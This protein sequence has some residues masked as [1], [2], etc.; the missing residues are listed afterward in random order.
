MNKSWV[1]RKVVALVVFVL[2]A[3]TAASLAPSTRANAANDG[4]YP[5]AD[6]P[7]EHPPYAVT[8]LCHNYDWG[9]VR[10]GSEASTLSPEYH[11]GYRNCT[12]YVAW[13]LHVVEGVPT[14]VVTGLGNG[15]NWA[16]NAPSHG[17]SVNSTP[18]V[19]AAAVVPSKSQTDPG[20]VAYV[21]AVYPDGRIKVAEYNH[22]LD[23]T[24]D[25]DTTTPSARGFTKFV[26]FEKYIGGPYAGT[27]VQWKEDP[28]AQKT[29][30][31]VV[32]GPDGG[33]RRHWIP[34]IASYFCWKNVR[35]AP[36]P[37]ALE[38]AVLDALPDITGVHATFAD[39]NT[40]GGRGGGGGDTVSGTAEEAGHH[41][42]KTFS[43][44]HTASGSG[45]TLA[46][47]E[48]VEV[49]CKVLD[50]TVSSSNP[51]GYWYRLASD[52]WNDAYYAPANVFMNG[53]PW[54]GPY[55]HNTDFSVPDCGKGSNG[56]TGNGADGSPSAIG[57]W[58]EQQGHN[59]AG[60]FTDPHNASGAGQSV[61]PGEYVNVSCKLL[62]TTISSVNPDGYW[63]RLADAP[64]TNQYYA[65]ANTFMNGDPWNGPYS[66]NTDF[67]VPDCP[68]SAPPPPNNPPPPATTYAE[69]QGHHGVHTFADYHNASGMGTDI[70]PA[71]TVHVSCKVLDGTIV[72]V[73]PDGYWYRVA[74]APWND[75]YYAPANTFM[76]GDP[77]DGPYTH[78]TD[79]NV[80]D[81]STIDN[82]GSPPPAPT[83]QEQEGSHGVN[84]FTDYH[85]A[86]GMGTP[87][88]AGQWVAVSCKVYDPTIASVNPDGYWY[89]IASSPWNNQYYSPANTFMNGDP[90]GGPYTHNTDYNVVNC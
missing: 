22:R 12:D 3:A 6:M 83:W 47:A 70:A 78:N 54:N 23:G 17:L 44:Y 38:P 20:H 82:Q 69:Q 79:F 68:A 58:R 30:W 43:D 86:S 4:G 16:A 74:D 73:N 7:C 50:G 21:E 81:C 80:P 65:P 48:Y 18:A 60:A 26:H 90:W 37:Y 62:D 61:Q 2:A 14:A 76:N 88:S 72:S 9:P 34:D 42:A 77:W 75:Q 57:T 71:A 53:D 40:T 51:D 46:A 49:S 11:Y 8:G 33:W 84:T 41:G 15:G 66:H 64:W 5:Y 52:P 39:C 25:E 10:D 45:P 89:R 85:N 63:Y 1:V 67:N 35:G 56:G 13:R 59:G 32:P 31:L 36:G 87:I 24:F 19:G 28:K 27:I 55:T 29:A